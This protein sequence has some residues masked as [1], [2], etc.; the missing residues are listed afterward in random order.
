MMLA[1]AVPL[2]S[3]AE[4]KAAAIKPAPRKSAGKMRRAV[5]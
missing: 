1:W 3:A 5:R 4:T 2:V